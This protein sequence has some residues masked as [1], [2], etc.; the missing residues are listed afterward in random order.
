MS[1]NVFILGA[2]ASA[3]AG[4]PVMGTFIRSATEILRNHTLDPGDQSSFELVL[5]ARSVL[6]A[7]H[8]KSELDLD[9]IESLFGAFEMAELLGKLGGLPQ[10]DIDRLP[11]SMSRLI[12]RTIEL[13]VKYPVKDSFSVLPPPPYDEFAKM[14]RDI[15][16]KERRS[17]AVIT[18]NYDVALD[19]SLQF[20]SV[21]FDYCLQAPKETDVKRE[22]MKYNNA[23]IDLLK[24]HGSLN[25]ALCDECKGI[26]AW[27]FPEFF[28]SF[29]WGMHINT[30]QVRLEI[31]DKLSKRTHC[32]L[33]MV[34]GPLIVP[35]TW[36]KGRFHKQLASV[37]RTAA[38]HLAEAE[39]IFVIGYSLPSTDE[40]FRY[41]YALGSVGESILNTFCVVDKDPAVE[42]RFRAILGPSTAR[43]FTFV[44]IP[45]EDSLQGI[46]ERLGIAEALATE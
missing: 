5:K 18:F 20:N 43:R 42:G 11:D 46:R 16:Q 45:F 6:Q 32:D 27:T 10:S 28:K 41:F 36:N 25:W 35:P 23:S 24:L 13:L 21:A 8:S 15:N 4:A 38:S 44:R 31:A 3:K 9:N 12:S 40:F 37:W 39:N 22:M 17:V 19:Y 26:S 34:S 1:R 29:N 30:D 7:V 14:I 33:P 2:G